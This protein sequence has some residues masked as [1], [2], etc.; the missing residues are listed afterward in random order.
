MTLIIRL[1]C[2]SFVFPT[3]CLSL[4]MSPMC[5]QLCQ[6]TIK[7]GTHAAIMCQGRMLRQP[8]SLALDHP[9]DTLTPEP[10]LRQCAPTRSTCSSRELRGR[11][12]SLRRLVLCR[13]WH[14]ECSASNVCVQH[15]LPQLDLHDRRVMRCSATRCDALTQHSFCC[16][17]GIIL[18]LAV[19]LLPA[20]C[21]HPVTVC[22]PILSS[23]HQ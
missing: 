2:N 15:V 20:Q 16:F 13:G 6:H 17:A 5:E 3:P 1:A 21:G 18:C 14:C 12:R 9:H 22:C 4:S 7:L 10:S 11:R 23:V 8:C 19:L